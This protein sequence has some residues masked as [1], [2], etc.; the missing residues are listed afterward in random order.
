[1]RGFAQAETAVGREETRRAIYRM[2]RV[3]RRGH[4][5]KRG[6]GWR[7]VC[8]AGVKSGGV[9]QVGK[10]ALLVD[11]EGGEKLRKACVAYGSGGIRGN[12]S[13]RDCSE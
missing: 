10:D 11:I 2:S 6:I 1:M 9:V 8:V 3:S 4:V 12:Q 5:N 13:F 7:K